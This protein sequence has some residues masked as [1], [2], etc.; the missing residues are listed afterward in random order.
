V[1]WGLPGRVTP[2]GLKN[3]LRDFKLAGTEGKTRSSISSICECSEMSNCIAIY[4]STH[5]SPPGP[6][7]KVSKHLVRTSSI[8]EAYRMVRA[9]HMTYFEPAVHKKSI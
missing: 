2:E 3:L 6:F 9:L 5:Y 1:I 7:T 4:A 8:S